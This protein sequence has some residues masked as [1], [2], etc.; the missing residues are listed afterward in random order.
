MQPTRGS[1]SAEVIPKKRS[2]H[3]SY[4]E[5]AN[6][7]AQVLEEEAVEVEEELPAEVTDP[8]EQIEPEEA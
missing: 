1:H 7:P 6:E 2:Q 3:Y 8:I 5:S 4:D